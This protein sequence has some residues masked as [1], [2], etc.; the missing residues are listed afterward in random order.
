MCIYFLQNII[1]L[2]LSIFTVFKILNALNNYNLNIGE[3]SNIYSNLLLFIIII[4]YIFIIIYCI[5]NNIVYNYLST[6]LE[7]VPLLGGFRG[8]KFY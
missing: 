6:S 3:L 7:K 1:L 2:I 5:F 4:Y 8:S